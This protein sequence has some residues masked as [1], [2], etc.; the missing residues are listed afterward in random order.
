MK[1]IKRIT[2]ILLL[3]VSSFGFAQIVDIPD[4]NFKA[5]LINLNVD[6]N[7][8]GEIQV[9]EALIATS[10][11]LSNSNISDLTGI[12]SFVNLTYL[13]CGNNQLTTLDVSE[14]SELTDL[15]CMNNMLTSLNVSGLSNLVFF[16]C[17]DNNLTVLNVSDLTN[18]GNLNCDN[19]QLLSLD[20]SG[21]SNL[22]TLEC[23]NNQLV[24]LN[25]TNCSSLSTI[26]SSNNNITSL[27][28]TGVNPEP[29]AD[30]N[31]SNNNISS[32][33]FPNGFEI[34]NLSVGNNQIVDLDLSNITSI[35]NA[36]FAFNPIETLNIKNGINDNFF[37]LSLDYITLQFVC[38]DEFEL[39]DVVN[40]FIDENII[41]STYCTFEPGGDYNTITGNLTFDSQNNGCDS[42]DDVF[43]FIK[44]NI[45]DGVDLRNRFTNYSG[46]YSFY[47]LGGTFTV[48]PNL[49][50]TSFF[51]VTPTDA[52]INFPN[53]N[54]NVETQ[55][56]C[57]TA[58]GMHPDIEIAVAP[59]QPARP[60]F[61]AEY[62]I[63]YKNKGNQT[64]SGDVTFEY[65]DGVLDFVTSTETPTTQ[66]TGILTWDYS[67]LLPFES[68][69]I[70]VTLNVN[71]T[72][73]TPAVN[74][75]DYLNFTAIVN[76]VV[77]DE[78]PADNTFDYKQIVVGSFDPNDI[79]CL[80][81]DNVDP[82]YIGDYLHYIINFENTGNAAAENVVVKTEID[83]TQ[84][85][86]NSLQLL[87]SSHNADVR[88]KNNTIEF[89]FEG[90]YL[91]ASG[92]HGNILLRMQ[93]K[94]D[95]QTNDTVSK[96]AQIFF[97]Y[98]FPIQTNDANTT[99][100]ALSNPDYEIDKSVSLYPN[101]V[102]HVL[103]IKAN[104]VITSVSIYDVQG[105]LLQIKMNSSIELDLD[106]SERSS[107]IY[108]VKII[109]D[110]GIH[111]EKIVRD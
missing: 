72:M 99:F 7:E 66:T 70:Y 60:G 23:Y 5:A 44:M 54:N 39:E 33:F 18:L 89:I 58:N 80:Q 95:L 10:L 76:P 14:L 34:P 106:L 93:T 35:G 104:N 17:Y 110:K 52:I 41:V 101:P 4:A 73:E 69:S 16:E 53:T 24:E 31:F 30:F 82:S 48:A 3:F 22:S 84:F 85:D 2:P 81:G 29:F 67:D 49:E 92:G 78:L 100:A 74:I 46:E 50:N 75:D 86:I 83:P 26:F 43:P 6:T 107:G 65:D 38:A 37:N 20:V 88:V 19:N 61:D 9:S 71:G 68:R 40:E 47:T 62:L 97:D 21:L 12:E 79:T 103:N 63:T 111:L 36:D 32:I 87:S 102:K 11:N 13:S 55:N 59:I 109:T 90:I 105:R 94:E 27:D 45:N 57:I 77:G 91:G 42:N 8:D 25:I 56:F 98:N 1:N 108:F 28:F 96:D 51:N 64:V 15:Y